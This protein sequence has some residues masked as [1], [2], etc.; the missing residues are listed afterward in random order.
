MVNDVI[1]FSSYFLNESNKSSHGRAIALFFVLFC[2]SSTIFPPLFIKKIFFL[3]FVISVLSYVWLFNFSD[4]FVLNGFFLFLI[5]SVHI[6]VGY[7]NG[8]ND[9]LGFQFLTSISILLFVGTFKR[10]EFDIDYFIVV[11]GCILT[12][13]VMYLSLTYFEDFVSVSLPFGKFLLNFYIDNELGYLGFRQFG[14]ISPPMFHFVSSPFLLVSFLVS[15]ILFFERKEIKFVFCLIFIFLGIL[16]SGSRAIVLLSFIGFVGII[17]ANSS[18][19]SK[20]IVI[21]FSLILMLI[22]GWHFINSE[23]LSSVFS[24][25]EPSNRIKYGHFTSYIESFNSENIF[26]GSGLAS[27]YYSSG[28]KKYTAQTEILVLDFFRYFG[29]IN[30]FFVFL[31]FIFPFKY[32]WKESKFKL[33]N[34]TLV[35]DSRF[36]VF[37]CYFLMSFTNPVLLSSVGMTVVFWFWISRMSNT[38]YKSHIVHSTN[39]CQ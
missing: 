15:L 18:I 37:L 9:L 32:N 33:L 10:V 14:S 25:D 28:V 22:F 27:E 8:S 2:L 6:F 35:F 1:K 4:Y 23:L 12:L 29:V 16:L 31:L 13:C 38:R 17:F 20:L 30:T 34:N 39:R 26:F 5:F 7:N 3:L 11:L 21:I 36:F 19:V 24:L